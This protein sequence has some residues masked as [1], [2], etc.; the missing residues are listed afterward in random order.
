MD[1]ISFDTETTG[2]STWAG[3]RMFSYSTQRPDKRPQVWRCD[4]FASDA[5]RAHSMRFLR[6]MFSGKFATPVMMH[7]AKF[8]LHHVSAFLGIRAEERV[9]YHDTMAMSILLQNDHRSHAL[10]DLAW[11]LARIPTDDEK[12][13][14]KLRRAG[15]KYDAMPRHLMDEYQELDAKRTTLL[16]EFFLPMIRADKGA[17]AEYDVERELL[18]TTMRMERRGVM[19]RRRTCERMIADLREKLDAIRDRA[20]DMTGRRL[21]LSQ[22]DDVRWLLYDH[23]KLPITKLT[24]KAGQASTDKSVLLALRAELKEPCEAIELLTQHRSYTRGVA[25]LRSY[26]D[27]ADVNDVLHP[28]IKQNGAKATGRESC[29]N[30]N[31]QN[32]EDEDKP[33]PYPVA[34]RDAFRPRPGYVNIHV[35]YAGIEFRLN[36]HFSGEQELIDAFNGEEEVD[37]HSITRDEYWYRDERARLNDEEWAQAR[38]TSKNVNFA[39]AFG[40]GM[41]K[42]IAMLAPSGISPADVIARYRDYKKRWPKLVGMARDLTRVATEQGYVETQFGRRLHLPEHLA[43]K[44]VNYRTQGTAAGVIKRAQIRVDR[45]LQDMTGDEARLL[46]PIHDELVIEWPRKRLRDAGDVWPHIEAAMCNFPELK[47]PMAIECEIAT[48]SWAHKKEWT[49]KKSS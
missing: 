33:N 26:L 39:I 22:P 30:P 4:R 47:V 40:A 19:L 18:K 13:V 36:V 42:V 28:D 31:L 3:A 11:E 12:Q 38:Q 34:A 41:D 6:R 23:A 44:G 7:N 46:L 27:L 16:G 32:V 14:N 43:Y 20:R 15:W 49:W 25:M 8:D 29:Q 2:L 1:F 35:D 9:E 10:K 21:N 24:A 45:I 48:A 5:E 17:S 37:I